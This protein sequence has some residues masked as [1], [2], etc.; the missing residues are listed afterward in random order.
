MINTFVVG[1]SAKLQGQSETGRTRGKEYHPRRVLRTVQSK[2][3]SAK[4]FDIKKAKITRTKTE[5]KC[6]AT[7]ESHLTIAS[8]IHTFPLIV[9]ESAAFM[10]A[11]HYGTKSNQGVDSIRVNVY[12]ASQV[13]DWEP[14]SQPC[15]PL[16]LLCFLGRQEPTFSSALLITDR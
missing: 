12:S 3:L 7:P 9:Q 5:S 15:F 11:R 6:S 2:E 8:F 4:S 10:N 14:E 16:L 13:L 1:D